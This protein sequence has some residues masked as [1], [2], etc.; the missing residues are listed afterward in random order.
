MKKIINSVLFAA[1]FLMMQTAIAQPVDEII[2]KHIAAMGGK[3]KMMSLKTV[4]MTANFIG[5][6]C[7]VQF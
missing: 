6:G 3:E 2:N 5:G 7:G 1:I 4:K